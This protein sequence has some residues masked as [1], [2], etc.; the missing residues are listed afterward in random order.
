LDRAALVAGWREALLAQ[1]V[2]ANRTKGYTRHPQ[3]ERFRTAP[4]PLAAIGA[5]LTGLADEADARGYRFDRS[6]IDRP[7]AP[8]GLLTVTSGQLDFE[9][10][11]LAAKLAVRSPDD[12]RR[13]AGATPL[14]HPLFVVVPGDVEPWERP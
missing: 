12:A 8:S 6:R 10:A 11:H 3:L 5:F 14:P 13:L 2:L 9:W 4:E 1:A 7:G